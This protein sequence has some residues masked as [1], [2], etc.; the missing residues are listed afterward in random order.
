MPI[1]NLLYNIK[2]K[3]R[4]ILNYSKFKEIKKL[5]NS[6][7][8]K[9]VF[10]LGNGNSINKLDFKKIRKFLN[11]NHELIVMNNFFVSHKSRSLNPI[12][13]RF[14]SSMKNCNEFY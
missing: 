12:F 3:F 11:N 9:K 6:K 2:Y 10:V 13:C 1:L 14:H 4:E 7:T 8:G 5:K